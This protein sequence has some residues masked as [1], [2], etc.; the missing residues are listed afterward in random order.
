MLNPT[1]KSKYSYIS[2]SQDNNPN[3]GY[4]YQGNIYKNS[5]SP[6]LY[7][8]NAGVKSLID[9]LENM[10]IYLIDNVKSIKLQFCIARDKNDSTIN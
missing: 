9:V 7:N 10:I 8:S 1:K 6:E 4:K 5:I 2:H 3:V